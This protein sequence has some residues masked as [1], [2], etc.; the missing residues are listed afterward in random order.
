MTQRHGSEQVR[1]QLVWIVHCEMILSVKSH[2]EEVQTSM[3]SHSSRDSWELERA[4]A[5]LIPHPFPIQTAMQTVVLRLFRYAVTST[6]AP[7]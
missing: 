7:A 6:L 3:T 1:D 4:P 5:H 2:P